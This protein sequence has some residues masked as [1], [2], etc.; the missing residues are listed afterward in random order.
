MVS[1]PS[2]TEKAFSDQSVVSGSFVENFMLHLTVNCKIVCGWFSF[3]TWIQSNSEC[4]NCL[5]SHKHGWFITA[6]RLY[7]RSQISW[8]AEDFLIWH[9]LDLQHSF[10]VAMLCFP[11]SCFLR[12]QISNFQSQTPSLSNGQR[13]QRRRRRASSWSATTTAGWRIQIDV[14]KKVCPNYYKSQMLTI[15]LSFLA[16][17]FGRKRG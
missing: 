9:L 6:A 4:L 11:S 7:Q 12:Q 13:R 10:H 14:P 17:F 8:E 2:H 16:N 5:Q 15:I 3:W 1:L